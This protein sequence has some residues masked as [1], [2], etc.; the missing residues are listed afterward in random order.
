LLFRFEGKSNGTGTLYYKNGQKL[1]GN[2]NAGEIQGSGQLVASNGDILRSGAFK[3]TSGLY[4]DRA[5]VKI[6]SG[7]IWK[8]D[9]FSAE[10]KLYFASNK[11]YIGFYF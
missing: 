8:K 4:F 3:S 6:L 11:I 1:I 5:E 2:F 7:R 10:G 9:T